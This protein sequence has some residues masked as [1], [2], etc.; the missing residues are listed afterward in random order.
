MFSLVRSNAG[1]RVSIQHKEPT[2]IKT[3]AP[4][5]VIWD[6]LRCWVRKHP[7]S[8]KHGETS[9][10]YM[11]LQKPP[12]LEANFDGAHRFKSRAK[13]PA[14]RFPHNPEPYWGPMSRARGNKRPR[15]EAGP[16]DT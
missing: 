4:N 3:D 1:Y 6:I 10:G 16:S 13:K 9:P 15:E 11:I 12:T 5:N 14:V 8:A 2:A 7:V